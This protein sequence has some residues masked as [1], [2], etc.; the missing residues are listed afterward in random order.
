MDRQHKRAWPTANGPGSSRRR[1]TSLPLSSIPILSQTPAGV[2]HTSAP[3][4][5]APPAGLP[6]HL[7]ALAEQAAAR[8]HQAGV[9]ASDARRAGDGGGFDRWRK[10]QARHQA[11]LWAA[12]RPG[13]DLQP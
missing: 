3:W 1:L 2:K 9:L 11:I 10:I 4:V 6:S 5:Y 8:A 7:A 13:Q 12:I